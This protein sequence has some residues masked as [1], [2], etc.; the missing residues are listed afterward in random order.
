LPSMRLDDIVSLVGFV[1]D[2]VK[3]SGILLD[4][5]SIFTML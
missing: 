1:V 3:C 5:H 2:I 4:L